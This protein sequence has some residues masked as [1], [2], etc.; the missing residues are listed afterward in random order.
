MTYVAG[1]IRNNTDHSYNYAQVE[2]NILN[3]DGSVADSTFAN[4]NN[5]EPGQKWKFKAGVMSP[6]EGMTF[7]IKNVTGF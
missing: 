1:T 4:V 5:L 2:I 7:K 6:K 3:K